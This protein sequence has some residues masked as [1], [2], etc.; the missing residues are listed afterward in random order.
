[1]PSCRCVRSEGGVLARTAAVL[2]TALVAGAAWA[3]AAAG[4]AAA[5]TISVNPA[6]GTPGTQVSVSGSGFSCPQG[7]LD[8]SVSLGFDDEIVATSMSD[9]GTFS[10]AFTVPD[11]TTPGSHRVVATVSAVEPPPPT[12]PTQPP[13]VDVRPRAL[14]PTVGS[15]PA[16]IVDCGSAAATFTVRQ[17]A[18]TT[19]ADTSTAARSQEGEGFPAGVIVSGAAAIAIVVIV[20]LVLWAFRRRTHEP[21]VTR[22]HA[23]QVPRLRTIDD[24]GRQLVEPE[25]DRPLVVVRA[26][27]DLAEI[28]TRLDEEHNDDQRS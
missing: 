16:D 18:M 27:L 22:P 3:A 11:G 23:R 1:V 20:V 13:I 17:P 12:P 6:S 5:Q 9:A 21:A 2:T 24:P 19:S 28:T 8:E 26:M 25:S 7:A 10:V 14:Q 4:P 15:G